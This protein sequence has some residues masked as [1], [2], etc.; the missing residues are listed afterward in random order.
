MS[1]VGLKGQ[2]TLNEESEIFKEKSH[3]DDFSLDRFHNNV[4]LYQINITIGPL[5]Y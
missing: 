1:K 3:L 5:F 2:S 4:P